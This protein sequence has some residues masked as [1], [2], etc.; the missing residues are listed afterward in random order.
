MNHSRLL[1]IISTG[2]RV[3]A[4]RVEASKTLEVEKITEGVEEGWCMGE[5]VSSRLGR[6][7]GAGNGLSKT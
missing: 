3:E 6:L 7:S 5:L 2:H 1:L 4:P